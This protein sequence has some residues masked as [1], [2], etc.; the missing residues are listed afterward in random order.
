[1]R[2][3]VTGLLVVALLAPRASEGQTRGSPFRDPEDGRFDVSEWLLE[4]KGFLPVPIIVTEP[5]LGY[6]GGLAIAFFSQSLGERVVAGTG[7][8][9]PPTIA[10]GGALYTSDGSYGWALAL[11][12]PFRHDQFRYLG[13]LGGASLKLDFFGFDPE[14]PFKD[15]PL[16]YAID[17]LFL[18]QRLQ[19]RIG[20]T[21]LFV[22]AQY[23]YLHAK[24]AFDV[25]L[26]PEIPTRDLKVT[27]G[28]LGTSLEL[29]TRDNFLDA[30]RGMDIIADA[31]WYGP[32]FGGDESFGK[33][34]LQGLFYGQPVTRW[35]Y[36]LRVDA[37][38]VSGDAPFFEKPYLAM[39]GLPA[40]KYASDVTLLG[41]AELRFSIDARWSLLGFGG[42]GRVGESL[43]DLGDAP[44]VWAGGAG[45]RYLIARQLGLGTGLDFAFGQDGEFAVYIQMGASWR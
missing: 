43:G 26:P 17:P 38:A 16:G 36:G 41:E 12:H 9:V 2:A 18:L 44:T 6:G 33:Y 22:G 20:K 4:R 32:S 45:F 40:L 27:V 11:F 10:V 24:T 3:T 7:Q 34:Q 42:A 39:R 14:S 25:A 21:P 37:R 35:G 23:I 31:M 19:G 5:A 8:L 13:A 29:D 1:V 15:E 30:R 28:G